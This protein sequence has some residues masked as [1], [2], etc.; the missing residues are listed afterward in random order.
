PSWYLDT[1][2]EHLI[3]SDRVLAPVSALLSASPDLATYRGAGELWRTHDAAHISTLD[4]FT[5]S[6][7]LV[8][9]FYVEQT[10]EMDDAKPKAAHKALAK[11]DKAKR[12]E[13]RSGVFLALTMILDDLSEKAGHEVEGLWH[14][15]GRLSDV[16]CT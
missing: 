3:T 4:A 12:T 9:E 2:H 13:D 11:L 7:A 6:P 14:V 8:W 5:A 1:F 16:K 10:K 15:Y